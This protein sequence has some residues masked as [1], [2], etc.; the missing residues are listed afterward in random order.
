MSDPEDSN[1][2]PRVLALLGQF[3]EIDANMRDLPL[4]NAKIAIEAYGF[5]PFEER[6]LI[7][8]LI[9]PWFMN[10]ILLPV[11][12]VPLDMRQIGRVEAIALP[13]G[14]RTFV[15]GGER[16]IG[17]YK[18]H[19]LHS[20][21]L[22]FSLPGQVRAEARRMLDLLMTPAEEN[23]KPAGGLDRRALLLGRH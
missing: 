14:R 9:T 4:Y 15:I 19:S 21:V 20:P 17:L 12:P 13:T 18:A 6:E 8:I 3:R 7:G 2:H 1:G 22:N 11:E 10:L 5:R 16:E 23:T